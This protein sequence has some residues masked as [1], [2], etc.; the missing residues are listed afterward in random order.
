MSVK[1]VGNL[2]SIAKALAAAAVFAWLFFGIRPFAKAE[3]IMSLPAAKPVKILEVFCESRLVPVVERIG[4]GLRRSGVLDIRI[5]AGASNDLLNRLIENPK[6]AD[7]LLVEGKEAVA[8]AI[9]SGLALETAFLTLA[10]DR[11]IIAARSELGEID[12][13]KRLDQSKPGK[14]LLPSPETTVTGLHAKSALKKIG[15]W[16]K[17]KNRL[18]AVP[19][20]EDAVRRL[21]EGEAELAIVYRS[22][23]A[24]AAGVRQAMAF[25]KKSYLP[26]LYFGA[27]TAGSGKGD[28][29]RSFLRMLSGPD[30]GEIWLESGFSP[31]P[32]D[33]P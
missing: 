28:L 20:H 26:I 21:V 25:P 9:Q 8:L 18:R 23:I 10:S 29:A 14:A 7:V 19:G 5:S 24:G 22:D 11:L 17:A 32:D 30:S 12:P 3:D 6:A 13:L 27:P 31:P 2:G 33:M 1:P 16:K 15:V 4:A